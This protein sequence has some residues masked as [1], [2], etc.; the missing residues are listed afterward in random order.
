MDLD[1]APLQPRIDLAM[2]HR[3]R[4]VYCPRSRSKSSGCRSALS[5]FGQHGSRSTS[6]LADADASAGR[7]EALTDRWAARVRAE[8]AVEAPLAL[9][10]RPGKF[11]SRMDRRVQCRT[12]A[13]G[14]PTRP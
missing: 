6:R 11:A 10:M 1:G 7:G 8:Q 4:A 5:V 14:R 9:P 2:R 3:D 13:P 12:P